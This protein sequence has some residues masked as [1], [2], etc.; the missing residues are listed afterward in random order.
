MLK[1]HILKEFHH[2]AQI[3]AEKIQVEDR[4]VTL[5]GT[6]CSWPEMEGAIK[7]A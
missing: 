1:S 7:E 5:R 4:Q 2:N 3:D 6:V